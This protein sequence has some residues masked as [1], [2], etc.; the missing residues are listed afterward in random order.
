MLSS[1]ELS[2]L[3]GFVLTYARARLLHLYYEFG[4]PRSS[5]LLVMV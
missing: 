5:R 2:V 4:D 3:T 1:L